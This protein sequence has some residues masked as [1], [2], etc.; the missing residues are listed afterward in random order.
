MFNDTFIIKN[1]INIISRA[2][3]YS[4]TNFKHCTLHDERREKSTPGIPEKVVNI[5]YAKR[6]RACGGVV[7][8]VNWSKILLI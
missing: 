3:G 1:T 4:I 5:K 8:I 2:N 7:A 6:N